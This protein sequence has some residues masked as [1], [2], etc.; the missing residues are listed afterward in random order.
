MS[1][2]KKLF[3][4]LLFLIITP[5]LS[6]SSVELNQHIQESEENRL[7]YN[8]FPIIMYDSDI[9]FGFGGKGI[10]KNLYQKNESFDLIFFA[11]TKGEQW[12]VFAFSI[13]DFEIRQGKKYDLAFD[14]II[15][16]DKYLKSNF[17]GFGNNSKDNDWQFPREFTRIEVN[18]GHAFSR[19]IIYEIKACYNHT[20]VYDYKMDSPFMSPQIPGE[21]EKQT[22]YLSSG[23]RWDTRDSQI[24]PRDGW[25]LK[26]RTDFALKWLGADY[27]FSR[28]RLEINKY[29]PLFSGF[30]I[31]AARIWGQHIDGTAPYYE[32]S[33]I[34][35]SNT[36]RGYKADRFIDSDML[37]SSLEYRFKIY[38]N[39]G[40]VL[41]IDGGRVFSNLTKEIL[42]DWKIN[43][44][45]GLRYY[46]TNFTVRFDMGISP[47]STRIFFNF[48]HVF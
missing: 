39:Y 33:I 29:Q 43:W 21:G 46:L 17:F 48:G 8:L 30:H 18:L 10:V 4:Q 3:L 24:H 11:S 31:L 5:F 1:H 13:P 28:Y 44:G 19:S 12:Y 23:L 16:F 26:F 42:T 36:A 45:W 6:F 34:G 25:N 2:I 35:G 47:E 27:R 14:A 32:Q 9:G 20:S 40:G 22:F 38:K 41:F 37:L 15:E 7:S